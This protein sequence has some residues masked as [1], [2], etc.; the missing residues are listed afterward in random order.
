MAGRF[1]Q[2]ILFTVA[3]A[4]HV[5]RAEAEA[6]REPQ[7]PLKTSRVIYTDEAIRQA[8]DNIAKYASAKELADRVITAAD[9][10]LGWEDPALRALIPD[11]RVPRAFN[12]GTAGCPKCGKKIYEQGGT[13]PW[14]LD[15]KRPFKVTCPV[16]NTAFPDNDFG[17]YYDSGLKDK[18]FL[19]GEY[20]DNGWGWVGPDGNAKAGP[21][22][23][24]WF[25]AYANHWTLHSH[26]VPAL[27]NLSLA[28]LLT[29]DARY[30]H[31]AV[32]IL[33]RIAEVYPGMDY[34]SQ[35]RYGQLTDARGGRYPGKL[36]N[37]IWACG[38][39]T[40]MA[41][42]YD[43]VWETID[44]DAELEAALGKTGEQIRANIEA[45]LLEE[46]IDGVLSGEIR[47]NFGMHQ[48]ALV[49]TALARQHG[50]TDE[51][52]G[53][54]LDRSS[55]SA[56]HSGLN[57]ALYN[58]VYRDG[59]PYETSPGYNSGWVGAISTIA[60]ALKGTQWDIYALPKTRWLYDGI[61]DMVTV[62]AFTPA[63]GD[64]SNVYGGSVA[65]TS[66][67][68]PAYQAYQDPRYLARLAALDA[69]GDNSFRTYDSLFDPPIEGADAT[70]QP[71]AS[72]LLDGYGM[73]I[74]NNAKDTIAA[75]IYYGFKGGHGHFDRLNFEIFA[76]G[77]PM[78]PDT[79]YPDFM[80]GYVPGIYTWSK[81][82]IAHNTVTVDAQRQLG[83]QAGTVH[84]FV[85]GGF[86][87]VID[88]DAPET[89]P[90]CSTYRRCLVMVDV[91]EDRSYFVDFFTVE[92][93]SQHDY[94]LHGPPGDCTVVGG[95]WVTQE[96]GTLAGEDVAIAEI[97]DDPARGAE[98]YDGTYYGY[99]G[100]GFQHLFD[101][102][103]HADNPW[104][105]EYAHAKDP[106]AL[107]RVRVLPE[108][109]TEI[110]LAHAQVSPVKHKQLLKYI[111][112]RRR[113]DELRSRY[114]GVLEPFRKVAL[115]D[116]ARRLDLNDSGATAVVVLRLDGQTDVILYNP[117][118]AEL[119]LDEFEIV[120]RA[121]V[122]AATV[123][124]GDQPLRAFYT[125]ADV[126]S[127]HG[128]GMQSFAMPAGEVVAVR[129]RERQ[130]DVR[131]DDPDARFNVG[132]LVGRA[133]HFHNDLRR[134]AHPVKAA[135]LDGDVLTLTTRDHLLVG[136]FRV[137]A[138]E[139]Q[140]LRTD[141]GFMFDPVYRGTYV[142]DE[143]FAAC[144]AI[145]GVE[146]PDGEPTAV[147]LSVLLRDGQPFQAGADT[148]I[149]NVG[150]GDRLHVPS[151][152]H[153]RR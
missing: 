17:A 104:L 108:P 80:N 61:L 18:G 48:R 105:L 81:N 59:L 19:Q 36:V 92:G 9:A 78:M 132:A 65:K 51:W 33:D 118:R 98:G 144:Y 123:D 67:F 72:R 101:V 77:R 96:K 136:R 58:L 148:W 71:Q 5:V 76:H 130:L 143:A 39:L 40:S 66:I 47:G 90:Q 23:R 2:V 94:S 35:S 16:C 42:A 89:Y 44:A 34:H 75:S 86:A 122:L 103:R 128:S 7:F 135:G 138:V 133:V 63:V 13:Y 38:N 145:M 11:A 74:L 49:Y 12:V 85:D 27:S 20:S 142:T 102:E 115:I 150:P 121:S 120:T 4:V 147:R 140:A 107:L 99:T 25:V 112:A 28:Y 131:L 125:D 126:L 26:V 91:D 117:T 64:S 31:K 139:P 153:W 14:K 106:E 137:T 87:R 134:T 100:S 110:I 95:E 22:E 29:G 111:I 151:V 79:G 54:V 114:V 15:L 82:T 6:P 152:F 3:A 84:L 55:G 56:L 52:L 32:A 46:G 141:T 24:Y 116:E 73:G 30:A 149:V 57:Y 70:P 43:A 127:W 69:V 53:S 1:G 113:G 109:G 21:G 62:G 88:V 146:T 50:K 83:N 124:A 68:Q 41:R 93:G 37:L 45:N 119:A 60:E 8:R 97:Y 129:P 10:W